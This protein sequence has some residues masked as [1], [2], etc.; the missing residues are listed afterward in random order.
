MKTITP[1]KITEQMLIEAG[2]TKYD[3]QVSTGDLH[4]KAYFQK[5]I[6]DHIIGV[7]FWNFI[8]HELIEQ[9]NFE[10]IIDCNGVELDIGARGIPDNWGVDE[11]ET[12][13]NKLIRTLS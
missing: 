8:Q 13:V 9:I 1:P 5:T 11:F 2:Y 4:C 7:S 10:C 6:S 12:Y 3:G